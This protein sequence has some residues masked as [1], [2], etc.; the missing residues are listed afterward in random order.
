MELSGAAIVER[1]CSD[2]VLTVE[3]LSL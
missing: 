1:N 2:G 3:S